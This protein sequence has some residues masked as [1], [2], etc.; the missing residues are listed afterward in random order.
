MISSHL[1]WWQQL[2]QFAA[3]LFLSFRIWQLL[4]FVQV[5]GSVLRDLQ[6]SSC[7]FPAN[8]CLGQMDHVV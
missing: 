7:A 8:F 3:R 1:H 4:L 5:A 2:E 6:E